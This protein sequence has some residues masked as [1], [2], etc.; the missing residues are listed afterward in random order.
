M[1]VVVDSAKP[2]TGINNFS[3]ALAAA[4]VLAAGWSTVAQGA[5]NSVV[6]CDGEIRKLS[7][8]DVSSEALVANRVDHPA[9]E[10]IPASLETVEAEANVSNVSAPLLYLTPRVADLLRDVF[11]TSNTTDLQSGSDES[12][13][14]PVADQPNNR[15][16]E[17]DRLEQGDKVDPVLGVNEE[18]LPR[19]QQQM[20]RKDI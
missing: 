5:A 12:H 4:L 8:L 2:R 7:S 15:T 18:I 6:S 20:F 1:E 13:S 3:H 11:Q 17:I 16:E 10:S 14:S 9:S 19:F